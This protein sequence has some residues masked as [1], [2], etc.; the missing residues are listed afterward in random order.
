MKVTYIGAGS[1][2]FG[3]G[4][5]KNLCAMAKTLPLEVTLM[6]INEPILH[7]MAKFLNRMRKDHKV[8]DMIKV[9]ITTDR[10]QALE[11]AG[12]VLNSIAVG[13]QDSDFYDIH[14]PQKFGIPQNT[15]D[16]VGPGGIFRTLRCVP[17]VLDF[18]K[19]QAE[20]CPDALHINFT[21]PQAALVLAAKQ[22]YPQVEICGFSRLN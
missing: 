18:I 4:L 19:D 5:F 8:E 9:H 10:R 15:G 2:R 20:I 21:N 3:Y 11:N 7:L 16:T 14:I 6:D 17:V 22:N 13:L 12:V 1:F